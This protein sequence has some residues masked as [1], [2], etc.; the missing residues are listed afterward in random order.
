[1]FPGWAST[2]DCPYEVGQ[3]GHGP[4]S[5][6]EVEDNL[7]LV[8]SGAVLQ[9]VDVSQPV[10]LRVLGELTLSGV[11]ESVAHAGGDQA[12]V[13][14]GE[15]GLW[16]VDLSDPEL[17]SGARVQLGGVAGLTNLVAAAGTRAF[18]VSQTNDGGSAAFRLT[19]LD[20][21]EPMAPV[22]L[23]SFSREGLAED[24]AAAGEMVYLAMEHHELYG[25][26]VRDPQTPRLTTYHGVYTGDRYGKVRV[27]VFEDVV[28][29]I[30]TF[31][32][33]WEPSTVLHAVA[34]DSLSL[35]WQKG[36]SYSVFYAVDLESNGETLIIADG[37]GLKAIDLTIPE[38]PIVGWYEGWLWDP[39]PITDIEL[40]EEIAFL[41]LADGGLRTLDITDPSE[42]FDIGVLD[43]AGWYPLLSMIR[44]DDYLVAASYSD[45]LTIV[46]VEDPL[47]PR[48]VAADP[49]IG[50]GSGLAISGHHLFVPVQER[51]VEIIDIS[52]PE[53][54]NLIGVIST[55]GDAVG[56]A[57]D[58]P[59]LFV[60]SEVLEVFDIT[61]PALPS[62]V[63]TL[64]ITGT[65][66][67]SRDRLL[68]GAPDGLRIVDVSDG[69][70]P[71]VLGW[72]E[73]EWQGP[74]SIVNAM[75]STGDLIFVAA[76][77]QGPLGGFFHVVDIA[78]PAAPE[79]LASV[80]MGNPVAGMTIRDGF[81]TAG[82]AH[83][84]VFVT[85]DVSDPR[86]PRPVG[87]LAATMP[88]EENPDDWM[89]IHG[90]FD[91]E[92]ITVV[93][94]H[95]YGGDELTALR[96]ID[97]AD[98]AQPKFIGTL[99]S[100]GQTTGVAAAEGLA[101]STGTGVR[102]FDLSDPSDPKS[103][104]IAEGPVLDNQIEIFGDVAYAA[105]GR[106]GLRII[107]LA[108]PTRPHEIERV[109]MECRAID[110]DAGRL[111]V[112]GRANPYSASDRLLKIFNL[113]D[114]S[115]PVEISSYE[116]TQ[117]FLEIAVLDGIAVGLSQQTRISVM[118]VSDPNAPLEI[119]Y[120]YSDGFPTSVTISGQH[121]YLTTSAEY[122]GWPADDLGL[123]IIDISD[124]FHPV[125]VATVI[126][127]GDARDV[128]VS[129][130]LAYVSDGDN[131]VL[132]FDITDPTDPVEVRRIVTPGSAK[133]VAVEGR[134]LVVA[135]GAGGLTTLN[136]SRCP[137]DG[138]NRMPTEVD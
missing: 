20:V 6:I 106:S 9:V 50:S 69:S 80:D 135:D 117:G 11:I 43:L 95:E 73:T 13:A 24:I 23:G 130:D 40:V 5:A 63:A 83:Q 75:A 107:D 67:P 81:L 123:N 64:D 27:S 14:T 10:S 111:Y 118:D 68:L 48:L 49:S 92:S 60:S 35:L 41:G 115:H 19:I 97:M 32:Y 31:S 86:S 44:A 52:L 36:L 122:G 126:T 42:P 85:F 96:M 91:T 3:W 124:P 46:D 89:D 120:A 62:P 113:A 132:V 53:T 7:G 110:V 29:F 76:W 8:A 94:L 70:S 33:S 136:L 22:I 17:P 51:G 114:P 125:E 71:T 78:D 138:P 128:T 61:D 127:P 34:A 38:R 105:A 25:I 18:A 129:G 58:G 116:P 74:G 84:G 57:V 87:S 1:M 30:E 88:T 79:L 98:P 56:V 37:S 47:R 66:H 4:V 77:H 59:H 119:G 21:S 65:P 72:L 28:Y 100:Q 104:W 55:N 121:V 133:A 12:V 109:R 101:V 2:G 134:T 103:T 93:G 137:V 90:L 131:G 99:P 54:P 39:H 16:L 108:D 26:D 45:G 102:V 112:A 15:R 82:V